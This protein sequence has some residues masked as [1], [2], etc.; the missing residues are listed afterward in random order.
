MGSWNAPIRPHL[1]R[2]SAVPLQAIAL[3][4]GSWSR[5]LV[6]LACGALLAAAPAALVTSGRHIGPALVSLAIVQLVLAC[7][8]ASVAREPARRAAQLARAVAM[9]VPRAIAQAVL[10]AVP[11]VGIVLVCALAVRIHPLLGL[12]LVLPALLGA[13]PAALPGLLVIGAVADGDPGWTPARALAAARRGS[14]RMV[15]VLLAGGTAGL[16]AASPFVLGGLVLQAVAGP[17]GALG[18]GLAACAPTIWFAA[19]G[20][21]AWRVHGTCDWTV[22]PAAAAGAD[23]DVA[24]IPGAVPA[25]TPD[26]AWDG[27]IGPGEPWGSW[28]TLPSPMVVA[29]VVEWAEHH[30]PRLLLLADGGSWWAPPQPARTGDAIAVQVPAGRLYVQLDAHRPQT[31]RVRVAPMRSAEVA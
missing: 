6:L 26:L 8:A 15:G 11:L 21:A 20:L 19:L 17:F 23:R 28:L 2:V 18:L 13:A 12:L 30:P 14:W 31:V 4:R 7:A 29:I 22:P 9:R 27:R 10:A 3:L 5:Q 24:G 1:A 16:V 25:A